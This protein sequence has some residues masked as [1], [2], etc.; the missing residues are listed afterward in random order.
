MVTPE[1]P[2]RNILTELL[3]RF[4]P[5]ALALSLLAGVWASTGQSAL[6][7]ALDPRAASLLTQGKL[8][9]A[10]GRLDYAV[11]NYE[12]ALAIQPGSIAVLLELA[13]ATRQQ[14]LQG[15]ALHYYRLA[16]LADPQNVDAI[17]GEG[18]ALVEKGAVEKARRNLARLQGMCGAN[19]SATRQLAAAIAKGPVARVITAQQITPEP[20]VTAN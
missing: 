18:A 20:V 1:R 9:L 6:P 7:Q 17:S 19:C 8:S 10:A 16:L 2:S 4:Y 3:M 13:A 12:S 14:G 15:K 11:D 5:A